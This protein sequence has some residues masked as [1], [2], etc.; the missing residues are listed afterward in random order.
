MAT[1]SLT[2]RKTDD[3]KQITVWK[4]LNPTDHALLRPIVD[5]LHEA[6]ELLGVE[7]PKLTNSIELLQH[8]S[9]TLQE[10]IT[11]RPEIDDDERRE[12]LRLIRRA[13]GSLR[14]VE[15]L[16]KSEPNQTDWR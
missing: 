5:Q 9:K 2:T 1:T 14:D 10:A 16:L 8:A 3:G 13:R 4:E 11:A 6:I 7:P 12:A 15:K